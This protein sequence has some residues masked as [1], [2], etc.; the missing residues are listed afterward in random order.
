[1]K[2]DKGNI[3]SYYHVKLSVNQSSDYKFW[4]EL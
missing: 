1:M 2:I 3:L 4:L